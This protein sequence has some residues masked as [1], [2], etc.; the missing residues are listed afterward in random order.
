MML[1]FCIKAGW[2]L[3]ARHGSRSTHIWPQL[4]TLQISE[5]TVL[6]D[7]ADLDPFQI[8]LYPHRTKKFLH[9]QVP[10]CLFDRLSLCKMGGGACQRSKSSIIELPCLC[11]AVLDRLEVKKED[12][13]CLLLLP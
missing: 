4:R 9:E 3:E 6:L 5:I 11:L 10:L 12:L 8:G 7:R 2:L 1:L 13:W